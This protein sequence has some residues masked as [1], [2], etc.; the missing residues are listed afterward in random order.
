MDIGC[1]AISVPRFIFGT[2]P[3][4]VGSLMEY[5]P[6]FGTDRLVSAILDFGA[7]TATFTC[8]TQLTPYQRVNIFGS[9]GRV[10]IEIP[11][12]APPD[13]PCKLWHQ[14]G[15]ETTEIVL[16][17]CDQYTI[18]ADLF[19][20]AILDNTAVPTPLADAIANMRVI[21]A[22]RQSAATGAWVTLEGSGT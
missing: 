10:E 11:F 15:D 7:T 19:A 9:T 12:N 13:R 21:D 20:R 2:E 1:Y 16:D 17:I 8:G 18:Q 3:Q 4:R 5:D 6:Q 14:H 22:V